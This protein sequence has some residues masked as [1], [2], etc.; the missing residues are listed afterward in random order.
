[1]TVVIGDEQFGAHVGDRRFIHEIRDPFRRELRVERAE[2]SVIDGVLRVGNALARIAQNGDHH[3]VA[4]VE[5]V[6][7]IAMLD[8]ECIENRLANGQDE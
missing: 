8:F 6:L 7:A 3:V 2:W 5:E 1:M 4:R